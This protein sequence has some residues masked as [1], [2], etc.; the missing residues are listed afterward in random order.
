MLSAGGQHRQREGHQ[1]RQRVGREQE[2]PEN[3]CQRGNVRLVTAVRVCFTSHAQLLQARQA[4][5][6]PPL[7]QRRRAARGALQ[8]SR[9]RHRSSKAWEAP[10]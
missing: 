7:A 10:G 6:T 8:A 3:G 4:P 2:Q 5:A 9:A 1:T